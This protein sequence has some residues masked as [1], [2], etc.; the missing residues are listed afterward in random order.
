MGRKELTS[1]YRFQSIMEEA[2]AGIKQE[3]KQRPWKG[4]AYYLVLVLS[5]AAYFIQIRTT[6]PEVAAPTVVWALPCKPLVRQFLI[7]M[8]TSDLSNTSIESPSNY[9]GLCQNDIGS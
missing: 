2:K 5:L 8:A 9:S 1:S 4:T 7:D 3:L 6:C